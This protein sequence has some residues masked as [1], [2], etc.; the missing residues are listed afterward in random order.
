MRKIDRRRF[1]GILSVLTLG[2][3]GLISSGINISSRASFV[4]I[5]SS[6]L[7]T[8]YSSRSNT[9]SGDREFTDGSSGNANSV[10]ENSDISNDDT[11]SSSSDDSE[12]SQV[13]VS[14]LSNPNSSE[15]NFD[16]RKLDQNNIS[17]VNTDR[18]KYTNEG[19]FKGLSLLGLKE[20]SRSKIGYLNVQGIP[21]GRSP[22]LIT[23]LGDIENETDGRSVTI[24]VDIY[25]SDGVFDSN[26][27]LFPYRVVNLN[28]GNI[29]SQGQNLFDDNVSIEHNEIIEICIIIDLISDNTSLDSLKSINSIKFNII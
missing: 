9:N 14:V 20:R 22:L 1:I 6:S 13:T 26:E 8:S 27:L 4:E 17:I 15:N 2:L 5:E 18:V 29:K 12:G 28:S 7:Q 11:D 3:G 23:N 10:S 24:N 25:N 21:K 19:Y 16:S